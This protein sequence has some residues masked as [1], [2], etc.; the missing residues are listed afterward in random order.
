VVI[1]L[2]AFAGC[3]SMEPA[4]AEPTIGDVASM[5]RWIDGLLENAA[6]EGRLEGGIVASVSA[7]G[8][9]I[10]AGGTGLADTASAEA[11]DG[12]SPMAIGS[13]S[14]LFTTVAVMQLVED[15]R[16]QLDDPLSAYLP[17]LAL[18][19]GA[20]DRI[21]VRDLLTHHS[22]LPGDFFGNWMPEDA[23]L[24]A[25]RGLPGQLT[26]LSLGTE[27]GTMFSYS[28]LGFALLGL[29]V[30]ETSGLGYD[31]YIRERIFEPAGM[32]RSAVYPG[33]AGLDLT[34]GFTR[35]GEIDVPVIR[36][37]PAGSLL[38][39][40]GDM[41]RFSQALFANENGLLAPDTRDAMFVRQNGGNPI[42]REFAIG[43]GFWLIDPLETGEVVAA[44]G[45]N[46]PPA[47]NSVL[48]TMPE[49]GLSIFVASNDER[50]G[51]LPVQ[52]ALEVM[53][54]LLPWSGYDRPQPQPAG[55]FLPVPEDELAAF[56]GTYATIAGLVEVEPR[57]KALRATVSG[58]TLHFAPRE[59][60][61]YGVQVRLLGILPIRI[62]ALEGMEF[63]MFV[64]DGK[65]WMG[66]WMGGV[67]AGAY[68]RLDEVEYPEEYATYVGAYGP[69]GVEMPV[70]NGSPAVGDLLVSQ[71]GDRYVLSFSLMGLPVNS[72]LRP[73]APGLA[74]TDG[75][76]RGA[77]EVVAFS[78]AGDAVVLEWSGLRF[79]L[80]E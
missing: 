50:G 45:G 2:A 60:G 33:E 75:N 37:A 44:H 57:G 80:M 31:E 8:G 58:K 25:L 62:A 51:E 41:A 6:D 77:G 18:A 70:V 76:G 54:E 14:K 7:K 59:N 21:T 79:A 61:R 36:D 28:N 64:E 63:D 24:D 66:I 16:V 43:L 78:R 15:A 3:A 26:G 73:S 39:S 10:Y 49:L 29:I 67:Y 55:A 65:A 42:D 46:L 48:I 13:V 22:G 4:A 27:P 38:V 53:A 11:L 69:L 23:G 30:E 19:D 40:A 74:I 47:F 1:A 32:R 34:H 68:S 35:R 12:D 5:A 56:A 9:T 17:E 72:A 52:I 20:E 71:Q